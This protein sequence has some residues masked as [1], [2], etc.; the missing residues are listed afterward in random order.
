MTHRTHRPPTTRRTPLPA[1][2]RVCP[3]LHTPHL[4]ISVCLGTTC[5]SLSIGSRGRSLLMSTP[6]QCV[7]HEAGTEYFLEHELLHPWLA[8]CPLLP[9]ASSPRRSFLASSTPTSPPLGASGYM[10]YAQYRGFGAHQAGL[11]PLPRMTSPSLCPRPQ[12]KAG[13][14]HRQSRC[15]ARPGTLTPQAPGGPGPR[16][17]RLP[18]TAA[19]LPGVQGMWLGRRSAFWAG[20]PET[21]TPSPLRSEIS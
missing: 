6:P 15:G 8:G 14:R 18:D 1:P 13:N 17:T 5:P 21:E 12:S 4:S 11:E 7:Q 19:D 10:T 16:P 9:M 3:S 20:Y 2:G